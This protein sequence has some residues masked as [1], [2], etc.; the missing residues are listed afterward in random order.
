M[1]TT[2]DELIGKLDVL[3]DAVANENVESIIKMIGDFKIDTRF[4]SPLEEYAKDIIIQKIIDKVTKLK[5][6]RLKVTRST[7]Y[8][9]KT[10][11]Y[12]TIEDGVLKRNGN[13][14]KWVSLG[15]LYAA[16]KQ[17]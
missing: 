12:Y 7:E 15:K 5:A 11:D 17:L 2:K 14:I 13:D 4:T 16:Y 1:T 3:K 6:H 9:G 8:G 10:N